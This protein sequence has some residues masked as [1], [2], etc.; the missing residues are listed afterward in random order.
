MSK[1]QRRMRAKNKAAGAGMKNNGGCNG[2]GNDDGYDLPP[3]GGDEFDLNDL[4]RS[5]KK[6]TLEPHFFSGE[7]ERYAVSIR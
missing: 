6:Q 5:V 4:M 3:V 2:W 1:L 7:E